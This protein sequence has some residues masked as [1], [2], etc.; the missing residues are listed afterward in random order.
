MT[1]PGV[2][3]S[4]HKIF[5]SVHMNHIIFGIPK[6]IYQYA[7]ES[8]HIT[9]CNKIN[10]PLKLFLSR[11]PLYP[12]RRSCVWK[13]EPK[14]TCLLPLWRLAT[15]WGKH[16]LDGLSNTGYFFSNHPRPIPTIQ[17]KKRLLLDILWNP[18]CTRTFDW[19]VFLYWIGGG[20]R[21]LYLNIFW[22]NSFLCGCSFGTAAGIC[23]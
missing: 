6:Y 4:P 13:R 18:S 20:W 11:S 22:H 16:L 15:N 7:Y 21:I 2:L 1:I 3:E 23:R 17:H 8:Y 10:P 12:T 19:P 9:K 5:L 14:S